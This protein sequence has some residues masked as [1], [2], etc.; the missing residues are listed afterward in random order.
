M[1]KLLLFLAV[2][3]L[4]A[5]GVALPADDLDGTYD[6]TGVNALDGKSYAGT[7][8]IK[9][10]GDVYEVI[11]RVGDSYI[12]TGVRVGDVLSVGYTDEERSWY[13]VVGYRIGARGKLVGTWCTLFGKTV[14]TETLTRKNVR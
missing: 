1:N 10:T 3:V 9:R 8:T 2:I 4:C 6:A 14:G 11:W 12:G 13:G 5:P 7:V